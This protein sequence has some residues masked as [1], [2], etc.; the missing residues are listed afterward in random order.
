MTVGSSHGTRSSMWECCCKEGIEASLQHHST[1][2]PCSRLGGRRWQSG[3]Q[4]LG[5]AAKAPAPEGTSCTPTAPRSAC[6]GPVPVTPSNS[7]V[8]TVFA[9]T[10]ADFQTVTADCGTAASN[11]TFL[12]CKTIISTSV[13][14]QSKFNFSM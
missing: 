1:E 7:T 9:G 11:C 14:Y 12:H 8:V 10:N 4:L 3:V 2:E 13:H 5:R 6:H